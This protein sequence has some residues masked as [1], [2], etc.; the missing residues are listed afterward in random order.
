MRYVGLDVHAKNFSVAVV[1]DTETVLFEHTFPT[2]A[3]NLIAVSE[4]IADPKRV[5]LE[6]TTVAAWAYRTL[7]PYAEQVIVADPCRNS[8]IARDESSDDAS[9]ARKL[10]KLLRGGFV[11]PVHHT[12]ESRQIFKEIV[13][14]YHDTARELARFKN[15]LKAKFRQHGVHCTGDSVYD[16]EGRE[17]WLDKLQASGARLQAELLLETVDHLSE[18]KSRLRKEIAKCSK[19][20][21]EIA[22]FRDLPGIGLIRAATFF[23][24]V[25]TPHRFANKRKL[26]AYCGLAVV[27]RSS[28]GLAGPEHLNRRRNPRLK[29]MAKGAAITAIGMRDNQF[30][31]QYQRLLANGVGADCARLT[32]ARAIVS[33]LYA[34]WRKDEPYRPRD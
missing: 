9:A 14:A 10:A 19:A 8:W 6:E 3:E 21:K 12:S 1:D 22:C 24:I 33:A 27:K 4:T 18:Q 26:W 15:K 25:D 20:F 28:D 31:R 30:L 5:V 32:V 34:M 13:L 16:P 11:H 23:A 29:D 17:H 2:S 7:L